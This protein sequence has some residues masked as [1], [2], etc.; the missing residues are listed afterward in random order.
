MKVIRLTYNYNS[1]DIKEFPDVYLMADSSLLKDNKPLFL[2]DFSERFE[3][4]AAVAI[5]I[6]RLGKNIS[7]KFAPRYYDSLTLG[8]NVTAIDLEKGGALSSL[9]TSF[10][11]SATLG[12]F[13]PINEFKLND[14]NISYKI[15][16]DG[17]IV[18]SDKLSQLVYD[19]DSIVEYLSRYYTLKIGDIIYTGYN[20]DSF[21]LKIGQHIEGV[22]GDD[23]LLDFKVK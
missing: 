17:Q 18:A 12:A 23:K 7:R 19:F 8:L 4:R 10:D 1:N 5:R 6:C 3:A 13:M 15:I 22:L 9:A 2:P 16:A 21:D 20:N 11:S 14:K